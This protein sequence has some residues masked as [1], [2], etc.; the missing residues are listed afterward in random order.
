MELAAGDASAAAH[1]RRPP[2]GR[3]LRRHE[4]DGL[5]ARLQLAR[6]HDQDLGRR[7]RQAH[8]HHRRLAG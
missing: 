7:D 6:R 3:R 4:Q 2:A 8:E 1:V 5:R